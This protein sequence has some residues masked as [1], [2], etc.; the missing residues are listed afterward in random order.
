MRKIRFTGAA[1]TQVRPPSLEV[2]KVRGKSE[3]RQNFG[4]LLQIVAVFWLVVDVKF[5]YQLAGLEID[6]RI[7]EH[8][9]T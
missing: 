3:N 6:G 4:N 2:S 8:A 7:I 9:R 1:T 5:F